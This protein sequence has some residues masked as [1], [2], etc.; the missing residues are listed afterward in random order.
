MLIY[1]KKS[2]DGLYYIDEY[3]D[4][5]LVGVTVEEE[6]VW[7]IMDIAGPQRGKRDNESESE[8]STIVSQDEEHES[9]TL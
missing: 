3:Q 8:N 7:S 1:G 5:Y 6:T 9:R 4:K 2:S